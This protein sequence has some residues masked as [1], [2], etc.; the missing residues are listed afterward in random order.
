MGGFFLQKFCFYCE[1]LVI[2]LKR[3]E[4]QFNQ[5]QLEVGKIKFIEKISTAATI[6]N[7]LTATWKQ[8][9]QP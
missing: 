5:I 4:R 2:H 9:N 3:L 7:E 6:E 8:K 1:L